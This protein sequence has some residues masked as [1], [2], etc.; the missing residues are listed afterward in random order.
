MLQKN[1]VKGVVDI[2]L[3]IFQMIET[4]FIDIELTEIFEVQVFHY[5]MRS[6]R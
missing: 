4:G 2:G 5:L 1:I 6:Y 3:G